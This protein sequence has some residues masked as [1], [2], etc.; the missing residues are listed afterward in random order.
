MSPAEI[1]EVLGIADRDLLESQTAGLS[2][3][4]K[5]G[6]AYNAAL[7]LATVAL[8]ASGYRASH[9][10]QHYRVIQ[11]LTLTIGLKSEIVIRFD[12]FRKKRNISDYQRAGA[13]S[14]QEAEE[15]YALAKHLRTKV[16]SWLR[17]NHPELISQSL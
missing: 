17:E 4:W 2:P 5:L 1:K 3:D 11:S 13:V 12:A 16:E 14:A 9:E 7:Q 6:I 15:M 8:S 10:G